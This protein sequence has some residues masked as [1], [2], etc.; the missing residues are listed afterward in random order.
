MHETL[1]INP[2]QIH[3]SVLAYELGKSALHET[4]TS[5]DTGFD[6]RR[7][8]YEG[9]WSEIALQRMA[10][11]DF[12]QKF[13][14]YI[15]QSAQSLPKPA[16]LGV[17][18]AKGA[19]IDA[20]KYRAD[21]IDNYDLNHANVG[22]RVDYAPAA[23][24][25]KEPKNHGTSPAY[26]EPGA[27]FS[28]SDLAARQKDIIAAHEMHHSLVDSQGNAPKEMVLPA[29]DT[30]KIADWNEEQR[31][32]GSEKRTP[33]A[34]MTDPKELMARMAQLKNYYGMSGDE[35]FTQ[36]HLNHAKEHYVTDTELDNNMTLF[37]KMIKD[38]EFIEVIN[39]LPV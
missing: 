17:T 37:F 30:N 15:E 18:L 5:P 16:E 22:S 27:V 6:V 3:D 9:N 7:A 24:F 4:V 2:E 39:R 21:R 11:P 31:V 34:Y 32:A 10:S 35:H 12:R 23:N 25:G 13:T 20:D 38:K 19:N 26:G 8:N 28:D 36:E 14:A 29:F 33:L 1:K